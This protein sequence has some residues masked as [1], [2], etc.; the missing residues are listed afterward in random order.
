MSIWR[1]IKNEVNKTRKFVG[2]ISFENQKNI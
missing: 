2:E 1:K